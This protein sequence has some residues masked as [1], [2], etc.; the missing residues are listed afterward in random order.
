M[1]STFVFFIANV[2]IHSNNIIITSSV[3]PVFPVARARV[4]V[5]D[6]V[7][8]VVLVGVVIGVLMGARVGVL[9]RLQRGI[10]LGVPAGGT[11]ESPS[12]KS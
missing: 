3:F 9:V 7:L 10:A 6:C 12:A 8:V 11:L 5:R 4:G 2:V 1:V